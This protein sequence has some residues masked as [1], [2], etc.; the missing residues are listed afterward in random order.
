MSR[1]AQTP[2]EYRR[3]IENWTRALAL[4]QNDRL[5]PALAEGGDVG[6]VQLFTEGNVEKRAEK[7]LDQVELLQEAF[8]DLEEQVATYLR[9]VPPAAYDLGCEDAEQ[10]LQWLSAQSEWLPMQCDYI[11]CQRARHAVEARARRD[12]P[13]HV[14]FQELA[15]IVEQT[16][17]DVE[18]D[19]RLRV[20]LNPMRSW[21]EFKTTVFLDDDA[22]LP[23]EVL[24]YANGSE[25][26]T[27]VL[28]PGA[29]ELI[30]GLEQIG[31]CPLD[32]WSAHTGLERAELE[33]FCR[34]LAELGIVALGY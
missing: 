29:N 12:R 6:Q 32:A 7:I 16:V 19:P 9:Q 24:F 1:S 10:F 8:D 3:Q 4:A 13:A 22:T 23:A 27:A 5:G 28:E 26:R 2:E 21:A 20:F 30:R 34:D 17:C 25:I 14:R 18:S 11:A 33:E 15:S 31:P